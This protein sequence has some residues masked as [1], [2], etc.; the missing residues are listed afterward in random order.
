MNDHILYSPIPKIIFRKNSWD[1]N[2][3]LKLDFP[4]GIDQSLHIFSPGWGLYARRRKKAGSGNVGQPLKGRTE[5]RAVEP[6]RGIQK[7]QE[8]LLA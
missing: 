3:K 8:G 2:L 4:S 6:F 5:P 7:I 1:F